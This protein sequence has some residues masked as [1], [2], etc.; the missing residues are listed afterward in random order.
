MNERRDTLAAIGLAGIAYFTVVLVGLHFLHTDVNPLARP[1]S[2]YAVGRYGN[3]MT[4][5]FL[6]MS[7]SAP[8][9]AFALRGGLAESTQ[10]RIGLILLALFGVST[11]LAAVFP[12][13]PQY[14]APT[15]HGK[16]H[17][18]NGSLGF[19]A[20]TVGVT[21][22]SRTFAHDE[23][24]SSRYQPAITLS[25]LMIASFVAMPVNFIPGLGFG[26]LAQRIFLAAFV[27]WFLLVA[28]HIREPAP[29]EQEEEPRGRRAR[30]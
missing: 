8:A 27:A 6:A 2:D 19:L 3:V 9:L 4:S 17:H 30:S 13:D 7:I 22:I 16:I 14:Y 12:I 5:A 1:V 20:L 26:G 24:W 15:T 10:S 11:L 23:D 18:I 29:E 28:S 25:V 21:L